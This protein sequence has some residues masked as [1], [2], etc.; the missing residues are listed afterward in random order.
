MSRFYCITKPRYSEQICQ[1]LGPSFYGGF[2]IW[3]FFFI[4]FT[5]TGVKEI[6]RYTKD[7][8]I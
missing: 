3:R 8:V 4:Y 2:V 1:S 5:I 6:V 7:F